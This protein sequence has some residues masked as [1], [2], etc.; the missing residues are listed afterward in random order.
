MESDDHF[1]R[2]FCNACYDGQL[3]KVQEGIASEGL[4]LATE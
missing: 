3:S 4:S 2:D 1:A